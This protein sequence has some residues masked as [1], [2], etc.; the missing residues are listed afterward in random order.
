M[1][2][3]VVVTIYIYFKILLY[4]AYGISIRGRHKASR[5]RVPGRSNIKEAL[6]PEDS[7]LVHSTCHASNSDRGAELI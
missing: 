1:F 7:T 3:V 2:M 4:V 6:K 5:S